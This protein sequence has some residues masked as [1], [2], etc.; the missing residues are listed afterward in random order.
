MALLCELCK[1]S[2]T[3]LWPLLSDVGTEKSGIMMDG[4]KKRSIHKSKYEIIHLYSLQSSCLVEQSP[5]LWEGFLRAPEGYAST[6]GTQQCVVSPATSARGGKNA[7]GNQDHFV[8]LSIAW[9]WKRVVMMEK[10]GGGWH[11]LR[12]GD[13]KWTFSTRPLIASSE[14]AVFKVYLSPFLRPSIL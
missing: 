14:K 1:D 3:S 10:G 4:F 5:A 7:E 6:A 8:K 11:L 2:N 9:S 13:E 12:V